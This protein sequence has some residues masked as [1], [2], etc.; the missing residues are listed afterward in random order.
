MKK[1][2]VAA[3]LV[4]ALFFVALNT[5]MLAEQATAWVK[6][7]PKDPNAPVLLF[8]AA[9]WCDILGDN[10]KAQEVYMSIYKQYP[11]RSDLCPAALYYCAQIQADATS[12]RKQA[13]T[14]LEIIMKEYP[15]AG[16][17]STKAKQLYDEVNY[18]R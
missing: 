4:I 1:L 7:H 14:Y 11:E 8:R 12:A 16:E 15:N 10:N 2:I 5:S 3:I 9:R 18:V 6:E 13:N 17:W